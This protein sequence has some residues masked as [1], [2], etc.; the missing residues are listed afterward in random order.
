MMFSRQN[1]KD[2]GLAIVT[3][4]YCNKNC[5]YCQRTALP[6]NDFTLS[7]PELKRSIKQLGNIRLHYKPKIYFTGGEPML[8]EDGE[9]DILDVLIE[10]SRQ[11]V[12]PVIATNGSRFV[13]IDYA[14]HFVEE[15]LQKVNI[16]LS[17]WIT[18]DR[19]HGNICRK[20]GTIAAVDTLQQAIKESSN[21]E[22]HIKLFLQSTISLSGP[23]WQIQVLKNYLNKGIL[24]KVNPL[25]PWGK[26]KAFLENCP[27]ISLLDKSQNRL[28]AYEP[29]LA[30]AC[31]ASGVITNFREFQEISNRTVIDGLLRCGRTPYLVK[32]GYYHCLGQVG[33]SWFKICGLGELSTSKVAK[34]YHERPVLSTFY[35]LGPVWLLEQLENQCNW[36]K[37]RLHKYWKQPQPLGFP[38]CN[39]CQALTNDGV[40]EEANIL[41]AKGKIRPY[42]VG[43]N[44]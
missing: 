7:F 5:A 39:L 37:K 43:A 1:N 25:M 21:T 23:E 22:A 17:I 30:L 3:H 8:W 2:S 36:N 16:P 29:F 9:Y 10:C 27:T 11:G 26:G 42:S 19:W 38:G 33:N 20:T 34:F 41:I 6:N 18:A 14:K 40:L 12:K 13:D 35:N 4:T 24:F 32:D 15:Y 31:M 28:G 44:T